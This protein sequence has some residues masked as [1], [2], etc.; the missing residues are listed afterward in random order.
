MQCPNCAGENREGAKF[1]NECAA[2][3]SLR[4]LACG[5]ENRPGAKF[6]NECA[7]L[8]TTEETAKRR[9]GETAKKL[10]T[11]SD[12]RP[13]TLDARRQTL[14]S[15]RPEAERRQL[16]VMFCD[17]VGSTAL[18]EQL[19]P[20][21]LR[22]VVRA[23]QQVSAT[24]IGRF[25]GH[26]AQYLG[27]G[28]LVYFGYPLAHEDDAQ[29]A[30]RAGLEI[31]GVLRGQGSGVGGQE[32][33]QYLTVRLSQPLQVRIGIHTGLVVVGEMGG[34]GK[35]EQLA[36]GDTPN[37]AARV[38]G[39]AEPDT[40][41]IS[42][43]T[44]RL[45]EGYFTCRA[46]GAQ[47][48]K[49]LSTPVPVYQVL[50]ESGV[51]SRFEV[52]ITT[53]LTP[54]V[55]RE[56][57]VGLLLERWEQVKEGAGQVVLLSG[58]A[59]IGKSRLVQALKEQVA[60]GAHA[61]IECRCS[62]YYQN[63][64][65]Y[66]VIE[67]LQRLLQFRRED[68]PQEKLRK[69]EETLGQYAFARREAVPLFA[70]L[71][72]LPLPNLYPPL[73]LT[74]QKQKQKTLEAVL[75]WLLE[76]AERQSTLSVWE[77]LQWA[78]P[79]TL[80]FLNLLIDQAPTARIL[81][82]LNFRPDFSPPWATRL[83]LT[84]LTLSRLARKQ[85]EVMI[86]R[87]T[88]GKA[89]PAE[90]LGQLVTKTDGVP[91]FVEELTKMVLESGLLREADSSYE[92][93]GPL[94]PLAIPAT[95]QDSLMA[96]LDR[97]ATVR[98]VAQLGAT[99]GREFPYELIQAVSPLDEASLQRD[100]AR[101]VE[102]E[103]LY[104]RGQPPQARYIFKHAM[105]QEAAYQSL[106]K[107]RKQQYHRRIAQVLEERFPETRETHPE[108][109][110]HHYTEAG[111]REQA[112]PYWHKAGQ[113]AIERSANIEA[114][115]HLTKGLELLKTLPDT[116]ERTQQ[117]LTL[118]I[119]LGPA[120]MATKGY[121]A[122]EVESAYA[123]ARALC[124]QMGETSELF[125][126][127]LG[128][129]TFYLIRG[130]FHTARELGEQL[131]S[132]AQ[133][134]HDSALLVEA[135]YVLG[136]TLFHLGEL[137]PAKEHLEQGI[138]LYDPQQHRFLAFRYGQDPGVFCL[139][140][141]VRILCFLGYPD[142]ALQRSQEALALAQE[143]SH[144][145]SLALAFTFAALA[146]QLRRE[147]HAAQE[148]A[149]AVIALCTEQGFAF[150]LA[151]GTI[152][153]GWALT[154]QEQGEEGTAQMRQGLAAWRATGAELFRPH[155]LALLA[156]AYGKV[157][158]AEEGLSVLGEA[159]AAAHKSGK[160][161]YEAELYRLKGEL[162]LAQSS[163]QSLAS[164]VKKSSRFKVQGSTFPAPNPAPNTQHL[165]P[166]TQH[167]TPST[168]EAEACFRQAIEI[169]RSQSAKA[170][171]LRAVMSLSRLW[172]QQ[173]RQEDARQML[174]EIYGWF[175][176]G[177]DTADLKEAKALLQELTH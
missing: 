119:T 170:W 80:E 125:P 68:T 72:S 133:R 49:G 71:L 123:R 98:E 31:V 97:L 117:E 86:E 158:Q 139:C 18:S 43:A 61:R 34:G 12:A 47:T 64:A 92:L 8:L 171:E 121:A 45:I 57:E 19:D 11:S 146:H 147:G 38:Q 163:V 14:D 134:V 162:T 161:F 65:L 132:L 1:C 78:D 126:A 115:R 91:L 29:R 32:K 160:R 153:R 83:H 113:R 2:P 81:V 130:E 9:N 66:P 74:P 62:P 23:Y 30:V 6:C 76:E 5:T 145:F 144:P 109:V 33:Q 155:L 63:S 114:I 159:L 73:T 69:L 112:T 99:L 58:E 138:A 148:Q 60:R 169:A 82:L 100:L 41:V 3:L 37:I 96:R 46:L 70:S 173:G 120:L 84:Q 15:A 128:L 101:L 22:E 107:S 174:T 17:L 152:L 28:L 7:A 110:A 106:L 42:A 36:L 26:I 176:E 20:E 154:V 142:Q 166:S 136:T 10:T 127:L 79:S 48:L 137:A 122:P 85:V 140:Y 53:G 175:T 151:M 105:I 39:V 167:P 44:H 95:L 104:Q 77:D 129:S 40:V 149:E 111:L 118:Q 51:Q 150:Y 141:M 93:T 88:G 56:Q 59:G 21:E 102:A 108:L 35:H 165:T 50:G 67:H 103:L 135:H 168:Q 24:V 143:L 131:L 172:Q 75:A 157:G 164:S 177:F 124:Q 4:C 25:A 13:Q 156:E 16:T 52:A 55:G 54:L 87:V 89:L 116:V 90:V 94:P 27:D